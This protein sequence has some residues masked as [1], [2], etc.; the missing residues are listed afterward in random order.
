MFVFADAARHGGLF[1]VSQAEPIRQATC[2]RLH[3]HTEKQGLVKQGLVTLEQGLTCI[4]MV[5][6]V[7]TASAGRPILPYRSTSVL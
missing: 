1:D 2:H 4:C 3:M 7:A 5:S 6:S